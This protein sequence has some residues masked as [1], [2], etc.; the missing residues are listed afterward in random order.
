MKKIKIALITVASAAVPAAAVAVPLSLAEGQRDEISLT[1][2]Q[3]QTLSVI[4]DSVTIN[5]SVASHKSVE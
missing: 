4:G 5:A 2:P 3:G 1:V